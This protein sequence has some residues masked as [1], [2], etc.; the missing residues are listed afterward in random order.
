V[1]WD[2]CDLGD[3]GKGGKKSMVKEM[4]T[5]GTA[6]ILRGSIPKWVATS[7]KRKRKTKGKYGRDICQRYGRHRGD[8]IKRKNN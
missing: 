6:G 1:G 8:V 3:E 2:G 7:E 5:Q 4:K